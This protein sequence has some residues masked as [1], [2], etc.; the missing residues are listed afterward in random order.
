M[1]QLEVVPHLPRSQEE[2]NMSW[3]KRNITD[4]ARAEKILEEYRELGFEAKAE[5]FDPEKYPL[6]CSE[7]MKE[8]PGDFKVIFTRPGKGKDDLFE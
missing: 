4:A 6:E 1:A 3:K 2:I 5:D 8:K 7:C